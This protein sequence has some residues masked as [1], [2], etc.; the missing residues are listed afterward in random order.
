MTTADSHAFTTR[1]KFANFFSCCATFLVGPHD[2]FPFRPIRYASGPLTSPSSSQD[3]RKEEGLKGFVSL[4][5]DSDNFRWHSKGFAD[6]RRRKF[7]R[8]LHAGVESLSAVVQTPAKTSSTKQHLST[9]HFNSK[10]KI[11]IQHARQ[12][13][14]HPAH[15]TPP[16]LNSARPTALKYPTQEPGSVA[17]PLVHE[18]FSIYYSLSNPSVAQRVVFGFQSCLRSSDAHSLLFRK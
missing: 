9:V 6:C 11:Q 7:S 10:N 15:P 8:S 13:R 18:P 1:Q 3:T 4:C 12:E 2:P 16:Q 5:T 14:R 17:F